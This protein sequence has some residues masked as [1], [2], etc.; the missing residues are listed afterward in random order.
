MQALP[1]DGAK[2]LTM[3]DTGIESRPIAPV[4]YTSA[5]VILALLAVI[6]IGMILY[7]RP[8]YDPLLVITGVTGMFATLG[9][10]VISFLK[11]E[12][13]RHTMNSGLDSWK[14]EFTRMVRAETTVANNAAEKESAQGAA[15][16]TSPVAVKVVA[17]A[18]IPVRETPK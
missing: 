5:V 17:D 15:L 9:A 3:P 11:S 2:N 13:T 6:L 4:H 12:E 8:L 10:S 18:P 7:L 1:A 14:K 16:L